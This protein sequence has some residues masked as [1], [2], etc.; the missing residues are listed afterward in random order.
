MLTEQRCDRLPSSPAAEIPD[1]DIDHA[2]QGVALV[3]QMA[4]AGPKFLP[5]RFAVAR[6]EPG[7]LREITL[8]QD[9]RERAT[10]AVG[11]VGHRV[12]GEPGVGV[13]RD[14]REMPELG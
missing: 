12:A 11:T 13:Q 2:E 9:I 3:V 7:D 6:V 1:R 4:L 8:V 5:D 14:E 10:I